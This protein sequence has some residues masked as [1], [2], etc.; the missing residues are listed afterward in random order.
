MSTTTAHSSVAHATPS[1][2]QH[3]ISAVQRIV[4]V[5]KLHLVNRG[6][7][8]WLP[9]FIMSVI[10]TCSMLI[11]WIVSVLVERAGGAPDGEGP[12]IMGGANSFLVIYMLVVAV[13]A[14]NLTFPFAQ[15]YSVTRRD[16]YLGSALT[17]LGLSFF[18]AVLMSGLAWLEAATN[19][20]GLNGYMFGLG[21]LGIVELAQTFYVYLLALL[22]FFFVGTAVAAMYVRW[23]TWG[24]VG[25]F[26]AFGF[27]VIGLIA[28]ATFTD[29][30]GVVGDWLA[31]NGAVGVATWSLI[32]TALAGVAGFFIL[33]HATP[34]A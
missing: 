20:W 23:R 27:L 18:Y 17:F 1:T 8:L 9:L 28:L 7:V 25:F 13:Q 19:G 5:A 30:W 10:W 11:W 12:I 34:R 31:A 32:V 29:S 2:D 24:V 14:I 26:T 3:T 15:G 22:L 4:N 33:R 21:M 16:F 6:A